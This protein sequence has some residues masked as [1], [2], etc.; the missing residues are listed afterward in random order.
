[1]KNPATDTDAVQLGN[2]QSS[3]GDTAVWMVDEVV[4]TKALLLQSDNSHKSGIKVLPPKSRGVLQLD[5]QAQGGM[6]D[7]ER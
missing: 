3:A 5:Q 1:V 2:S 6:R 4:V 7:K